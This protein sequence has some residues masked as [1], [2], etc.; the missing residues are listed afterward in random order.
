MLSSSQLYVQLFMIIS[1]LYG[2]LMF[3]TGTCRCVRVH[4]HVNIHVHYCIC[5]LLFIQLIQQ[6]LLSLTWSCPGLPDFLA[7]LK[8]LLQ[9]DLMPCVD[10]LLSHTSAIKSITSS[11][12]SHQQLD[13]FIVKMNDG[14][15]LQQKK[16]SVQELQEKHKLELIF[17]VHIHSIQYNVV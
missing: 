3:I 2:L 13:M 16:Q 5:V 10:S 4:V 15:C 6:G 17:T 11:W 12:C 7:L 8:S 1:S 9:G 14:H